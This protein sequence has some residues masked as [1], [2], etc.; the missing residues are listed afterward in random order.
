M[1]LIL[2]FFHCELI[3]TITKP[4]REGEQCP[5][6]LFQKD[7]H[8]RKSVSS[9]SQTLF[10]LCFPSLII[11]LLRCFGFSLLHAGFFIRCCERQLLFVVVRGLRIAQVSFV[12]EHGLQAAVFSSGGTRTLERRLNSCGTR[13]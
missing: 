9:F 8:I 10:V 6:L 7:I 4:Q 2:Q 12:A 3:F 13:A 11:F 5:T 1:L